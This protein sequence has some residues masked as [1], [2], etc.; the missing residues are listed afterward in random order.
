MKKTKIAICHFRVGGTDG[1]S[2]EIEKRKQLLKKNGCNIKLIAGPRSKGADYEIKEL[3]WDDGIIPIM[4]ENG[5]LYFNRKDL[6]DEQL[7]E[8]LYGTSDI[9]EKRLT[10]IQLVERFDYALV[11]NIFSFG[12][13]IAASRGFVTWI[14]KFGIKTLATHHDFYWERKEF[15][16]TRNGTLK[17]YLDLYMP[18]RNKFIKHVVINSLAKRDLM[19]NRDIESEVM[20]DVFDFE[21]PLWKKDHFNKDFLRHFHIR[22]GDLILLQATRIIPRKGIEL[23]ID[24]AKEIQKNIKRLRG[25]MLYNGKKLRQDANVVLILAGYAEDEK[26]D[27][28][29]KLQGKAFDDQVQVRF[30]SDGV[31]AKRFFRERQKTYCLW[32]AYVWSDMITFPSL[33]EGWG[34]QFIE[35]VFAKKPT[36]VFEYPVFKK[37]I[38]LEGYEVLSL[39]DNTVARDT[40]GLV[41]IEEEVTKKTATQAIGWLLDKK[42]REK[43]ERNWRIG[44]RHH[45]YQ[46][47]ENFLLDRLKINFS[48]CK[49]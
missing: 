4:K 8:A 39:G 47:L 27:Y 16:M 21:Q 5:F 37:D 32:D 34:N 26:R 48:N 15:K 24:L 17:K 35:A 31:E 28:L 19:K 49:K 44:K 7:M 40:N 43:L 46:V 14:N 25:K 38:A 33:W 12:G 6:S 22:P 1:V 45:N 41:K 2:L 36:V 30:I 23:S 11:H 42:I 29:F 18:P 3:E 9:I 20:P 10:E 13:H